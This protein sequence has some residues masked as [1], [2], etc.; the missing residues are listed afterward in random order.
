[1]SSEGR[2]RRRSVSVDDRAYLDRRA[3]AHLDLAASSTNV[4]KA[5]YTLVSLYI[6]RL[7]AVT[8]TGEREPPLFRH[9]Q[10]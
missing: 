3:E 2:V 1:M 7:N 8:V 10:P 9:W 4:V 5:H 6:D